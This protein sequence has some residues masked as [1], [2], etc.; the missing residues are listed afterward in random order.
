MEKPNWRTKE[1]CE[2]I[3]VIIRDALH[4]ETAGVIFSD[5]FINNKQHSD[6]I[7]LLA[8]SINDLQR[9]LQKVNE[10]SIHN[11]LKMNLKRKEPISTKNQT[12]TYN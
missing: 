1:N 7:V 4:N 10:M 12:K 2:S 9:L 8:E 11:G 3:I 5:N 6:D